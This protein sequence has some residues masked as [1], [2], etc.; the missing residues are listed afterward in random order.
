MA[1]N[2]FNANFYR[3][4]NP[5][6]VAAGLTTDGQLLSHFQSN[7]LNEGRAFSPLI[8]LDVYRSS[9]PDVAAAFTTNAQLFQHLQNYGVSEGR[10]FSQFCDLNFYRGSNADL[11]N[12]S[13][14]Q[15]FGHLQN[16]G[17]NEGRRFSPLVDLS[18][19]KSINSDLSSFSYLQ[20]LQHLELF[21]VAEA[22]RFS[23]FVDLNVYRAANPDLAAIGFDNGLLLAHLASSGV[24]EGRR[25]SVAFDANYYRSA[26]SDLAQL[27]NNQLLNHFELYGLNEGRVSSESFNVSYYLANN[28]DLRAAGFTNRQAE[29]H[30]EV[31]GFREGRLAAV[32]PT[33]SSTIDP[34]NTLGSALNIGVLSRNRTANNFVGS[35]DHDDYYR[36]T[37]AGTSNFSLLLNGLSNYA[38]VDLIQDSNGNG[39]Y[40][41]YS[42]DKLY[43]TY[44]NSSNNG[45]INRTLGAGTYFV[46]IYTSNSSD[47]NYTLNLTATAT[48]PTTPRDPGSTLGTALNIGNLSSISYKDFVG[49]ADHD[50][51]YCFTLAGTS[52]F[53]LLLNGLSNYANVDLIQDSNGNGQYDQYSGDKLYDT[54]GNSSNNGSINRTLGAGTYFVRIYTSNSSD[55]N[56]T[57]SLTATATPPTTPRDPGSTLGTALDIGNLYSISYK[58]FVGSVD[59]DDYYRFT[60]TATRNFNLS[61]S[62]LSNYANV[63]VIQDSNGNGQYDQY[64]GE[65]LYD[66]YGNSSNNGSINHILGA[67]TYFV[68]VY[69]N[70]SSDTNYNL[71][72]F[73][74]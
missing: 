59:H 9:N 30:F 18:F 43:D 67:G 32:L 73:A 58:D 74:S 14:E 38:N 4:A 48:P 40:D 2:L 46:R 49:S 39:Q 13:N 65:K 69:T 63:D 53:S 26:N 6:L 51:Y 29:Q 16:Y 66:T 34:G 36:F 7:G 42:G 3:T 37:L 10:R 57:L 12:L 15:L 70:N 55:T 72:L 47:T 64:F 19:Y 25:F 33:I 17:I 21:G 31:Y 23:T 35:A 60:L 45:S 1:V 56:Y 50:D 44:G 27:N 68:R 20:A 71:T 11:A 28:S 62:G 22:R 54:Y 5:D 61:L 52:N 8:S 41:Q 24:A